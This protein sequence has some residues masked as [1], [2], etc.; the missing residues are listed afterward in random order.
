[1]HL[2]FFQQLGRGTS[3]IDLHVVSVSVM[4]FQ[5]VTIH[6]KSM[7]CTPCHISQAC[8]R[9]TSFF[10]MKRPTGGSLIKAKVAS[11]AATQPIPR[12]TTAHRQ[13]MPLLSHTNA[14]LPANA[15]ARYAAQLKIAP[16]KLRAT[17]NLFLKSESVNY[18]H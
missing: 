2:P 1:M 4:A 17:I 3:Q 16:A 12:D 9:H 14:R 13:L 18:Q 5:A 6:A 11:A 7:A 8:G 15:S 10:T